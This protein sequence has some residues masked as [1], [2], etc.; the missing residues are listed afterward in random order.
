LLDANTFSNK[1]VIKYAQDNLVSLKLDVDKKEGSE[2]FTAFN[3]TGMPTIIFLDSNGK[4]IDR[5]IGYLP[6]D[7]Y[8]KKVLDISSGINTLSSLLKKYY[9]GQKAPDLIYNIAQK[10]VDKN[11]SENATKF[12]IELLSYPDLDYEMESNA[13]F[14]LAYDEFKNGNINPLDQ[15]IDDFKFTSLGKQ[16]LFLMARFYKSS[17]DD[18]ELKIYS[19]MLNLYPEDPRVLNAYAWRMSELELNLVDAL[20][21]V[22]YAVELAHDNHDLQAGILDTEAELLWRM[23]RF[24]EAIMT[25]EKSLKINPDSMYFLDQK[26]KFLNSKKESERLISS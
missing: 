23:E 7:Q 25:I 3:C 26:E 4:E 1:E 11:D 17:N 14:Q 12:F 20:E 22:R 18:T 9:D 19:Q 24:D 21:K 13:K 16:A 8:Q 6:P 15:F 2:L 10:Y 5:L